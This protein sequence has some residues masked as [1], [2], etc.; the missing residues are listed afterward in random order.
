MSK[1]AQLSPGD[2]LRVGDMV[3]HQMTVGIQRGLEVRMPHPCL[4]AHEVDHL[5]DQ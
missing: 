1:V 5:P 4:Q 2:Q 3:V